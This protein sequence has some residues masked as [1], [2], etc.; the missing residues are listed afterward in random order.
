MAGALRV[1]LGVERHTVELL[2]DVL[3]LDAVTRVRESGT[4]GVSRLW[5]QAKRSLEPPFRSARHRG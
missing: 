4:A 2:T 1:R 3:D 5:E